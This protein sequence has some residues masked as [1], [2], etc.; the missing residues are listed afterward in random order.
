MRLLPL[1]LGM[2][3]ITAAPA[4]AD[5]VRLRNGSVIYGKIVREDKDFVVI[6]I[7]RGRMNLARR[8]IVAITVSRVDPVE[9]A[10]GSP[11]TEGRSG[12]PTPT[13]EQQRLRPAAEETPQGDGGGGQKAPVVLP[14]RRLRGVPTQGPK[15]VAVERLPAQPPLPVVPL[16]PEAETPVRKAPNR[17]TAAPDSKGSTPKQAA[18]RAAPKPDW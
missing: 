1:I 18:S 6:E 15:I 11:A 13:P 10:G 4:S 14:P 3:L 7:G 17:T 2:I 5:E 8:D 16:G 12:A 9:P